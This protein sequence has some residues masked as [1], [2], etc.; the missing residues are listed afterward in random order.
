ME[1]R[2]RRRTSRSQRSKPG[3]PPASWRRRRVLDVADTFEPNVARRRADQDASRAGFY[4]PASRV[5]VPAAEDEGGDF[6][7]CL[8]GLARLQAN[9]G[10]AAEPQARCK[11]SAAVLDI[12]LHSLE[13]L[14]VANV[15]DCDPG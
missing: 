14:A 5:F 8:A 7:R 10:P 13:S 6:D 12:D 11:P 9:P 1:R 3:G 2:L 15:R 4:R